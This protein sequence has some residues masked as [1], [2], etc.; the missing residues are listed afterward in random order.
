VSR[1]NAYLLVWAAFE[2]QCYAIS[3]TPPTVTATQ[4]T[5]SINDRGRPQITFD[6]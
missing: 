6:S 3:N 1:R 4:I 2:R 5:Q